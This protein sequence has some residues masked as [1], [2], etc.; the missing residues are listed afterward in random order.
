METQAGGRDPRVDRAGP[1]RRGLGPRRLVWGAFAASVA[2]HVVIIALY[3]SFFP[4]IVPSAPDYLV[5]VG[6]SSQDGIQV[7]RVVEIDVRPDVEV[8]EEPEL[9]RVIERSAAVGS[10][11]PEEGPVVDFARPGISAV[12]RLRPD[13]SDPRLWAPLPEEFRQLTLQQR[14]E[15]AL[16]G[17]LQEWYDSISAVADAES[18]MTDWTF[19]DGDG[20]R[21]GVADGQLFLGGLALPLPSFA[22][23][24]GSEA[25]ERAWQWD[26]IARQGRSVAVQ[27]TVRERMEAI[28]ARRDAERAA[29]R[30][31]TAGGSN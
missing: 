28:R 24:P 10:P 25:R 1:W 18:A 26:E 29:Q 15:L 23:P 12:D 31:D 21:W 22:P 9:E 8:P 30:G 20:R 3:A 6:A 16:S 19:T 4:R 5:P 14:E 27:Q 2:V 11:T 17:R 13:I 7:M